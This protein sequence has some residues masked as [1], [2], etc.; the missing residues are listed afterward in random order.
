LQHLIDIY[1]TSGRIT[2]SNPH[3]CRCVLWTSEGDLQAYK[4][5]TDL[6]KRAWMALVV[7]AALAAPASAAASDGVPPV[8]KNAAKYCKALR[9]SMG[10]EAFTAAFGGKQNAFGKCVSQRVHEERQNRRAALRA[11]RKELSA[12]AHTSRQGGPDGHGGPKK[13][14]RQALTRCVKSKLRKLADSDQDGVLNAAKACRA[15]RAEDPGAFADKYG[16]N[17]NDRNAFGKCVS[18]HADDTAD[19]EKDGQS[20]PAEAGP[21]NDPGVTPTDS[22]EP[23]NPRV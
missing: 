3:A 15:E 21:D 1:T 6:M 11:C 22:P 18:K 8:A 20:E 13:H 12:T 16:S 17:D 7:V 23:D 5:R 2:P 19:D 10:A 9:T 14:G 4:G